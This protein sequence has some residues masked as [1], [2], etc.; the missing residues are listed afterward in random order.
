MMNWDVFFAQSSVDTLLGIATRATQEVRRRCAAEAAAA[1][2]VKNVKDDSND[3][4]NDDNNDYLRVVVY[5]ICSTRYARN[6]GDNNNYA[7]VRAN[8]INALG[9]GR[10]RSIYVD[11]ARRR[12]IVRFRDDDERDA[13]WSAL[14]KAYP[15]ACVTYW[16]PSSSSTH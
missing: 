4:D 9:T 13:G 8:I 15:S 7:E 11:V 10:S 5:P 12:A 6:A 16:I 1:A 3:D 14:E 2:A